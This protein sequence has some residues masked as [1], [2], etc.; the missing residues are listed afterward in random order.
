MAKLKNDR[1]DL[2][3]ISEEIEKARHV[4]THGKASFE[5]FAFQEMQA[6]L[7]TSFGFDPEVPEFERHK[8][9]HDAVFSVGAKGIISKETLAA[10]IDRLER[11]YLKGVKRRFTLVS[12]LSMIYGGYLR[13]IRMGEV[14]IRFFDRAPRRYVLPPAGGVMSWPVLLHPEEYTVVASSVFARN[15]YEAFEQATSLLD[16]LRAEWNF[17]RNRKITRKLVSSR[18]APINDIRFGPYHTVHDSTGALAVQ[19]YWHDPQYRLQ[20]PVDPSREWSKVSSDVAFVRRALHASLSCRFESSI[21]EIQPSVGWNRLHSG[22]PRAVGCTRATN[23]D[24]RRK[25]RSN[26]KAHSVSVRRDQH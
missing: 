5:G 1:I 18:L 4:N 8:I 9:L 24:D 16:E 25:I 10:G 6:V 15:A 22:I 7:Q 20:P 13:P 19:T 23:G 17:S 14:S 3:V 21:C 26:Y 2:R 12:S 11:E